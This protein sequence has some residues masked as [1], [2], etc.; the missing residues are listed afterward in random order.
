MSVDSI[1]DSFYGFSPQTPY[2]A[3]EV[4]PRA[5]TQERDLGDEAQSGFWQKMFDGDSRFNMDMSQ[6]S[7]PQLSTPSI[8]GPDAPAQTQFT[9]VSQQG[10]MPVQ[11]GRGPRDMSMGMSAGMPSLPPP[12]ISSGIG[13][14]QAMQA[15][16]NQQAEQANRRPQSN[17]MNFHPAIKSLLNWGQ[18]RGHGAQSVNT[19]PRRKGGLM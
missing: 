5:P 2:K 19:P 7:I 15:R 9:D 13:A 18:G 3:D 4:S 6:G 1:F 14:M 16:A 8:Q 10:L 17:Q 11:H 12:P